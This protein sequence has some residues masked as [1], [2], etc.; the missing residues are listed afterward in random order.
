[1]SAL[2]TFAIAA[3]GSYALRVAM[4]V[5]LAGRTLPRTMATSVGLVGPAAAAALTV[6]A[7]M[8]RG[9]LAGLPTI[10]ACLAAFAVVRRTRQMTH[11]LVVGFPLIWVLAALEHL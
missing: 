7:L 9:G 11:A 4:L 2:A 8:G 3:A 6:G 10:V 5:L 1:M